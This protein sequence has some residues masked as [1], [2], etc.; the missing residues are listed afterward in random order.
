MFSLVS[1]NFILTTYVGQV[2]Y[3]RGFI[4]IIFSSQAVVNDDVNVI[5]G[6]C[7]FN[8]SCSMKN[9]SCRY[10]DQ[11]VNHTIKEYYA[12]LTSALDA[13]R[14]GKAWGALYFNE[15]YTDSLV[16]RLALG[17]Y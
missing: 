2:I 5:N 3:Q 17:E 12:D 14:D 10:L 4:C 7:P 13:V 11:L 9:L 6:D 16:A 1:I 15:N 8:S